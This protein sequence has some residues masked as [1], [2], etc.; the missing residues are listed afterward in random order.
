METLPGE[1][2]TALGFVLGYLGRPMGQYLTTITRR[3]QATS[4]RR[5]RFQHETLTA[6]SESLEMWLSAATYVPRDI[7]RTKARIESLVFRVHD[8]R[9]RELLERLVS[10]QSGTEEWR[11]TY[12]DVMR[13]LG[14][15]LRGL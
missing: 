11:A 2:W 5:E 4:D 12:G 8:D 14:E 13:R 10:T 7:E 1:F 3:R 9:L 15:V 6:L